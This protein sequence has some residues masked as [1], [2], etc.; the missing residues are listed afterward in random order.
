[1]LPNR[2]KRPEARVLAETEFVRFAEAVASLT[3]EEWE[4]PTDCTGWDVRKMVLH[5]LGSGD[6]QA[7]FPTFVQRGAEDAR[8][9]SA[10]H[11]AAP[12]PR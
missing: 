11:G 6:A 3:P 5:V 4:M 2:I 12:R 7:S 10:R 9:A 1:M 8:L